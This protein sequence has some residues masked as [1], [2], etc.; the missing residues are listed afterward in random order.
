MIA[1]IVSAFNF[2]TC[3]ALFVHTAR[4][5]YCAK[6]SAHPYLCLKYAGRKKERDSDKHYA[7]AEDEDDS[8]SVMIKVK[9]S[10]SPNR[11]LSVVWC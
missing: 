8:S 11:S 3:F 6:T 2:L 9:V 1:V 4:E 7:E 10:I 5:N